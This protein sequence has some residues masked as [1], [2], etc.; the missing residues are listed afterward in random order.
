MCHSGDIWEQA[1]SEHMPMF[2]SELGSHAVDLAS[3][4][5]RASSTHMP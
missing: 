1:D 4:Q 5:L 3:D 2:T